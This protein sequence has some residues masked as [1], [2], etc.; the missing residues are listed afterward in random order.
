MPESVEQ[1]SSEG[2]TPLQVAVLAQR[3]DV[4]SYLISI[5]ANQRSRDKMGRTMVHSMVASKCG[6]A[7]THADKLQAMI[8]LFD[9]EAV[10]EMLVERCTLHPGALTPLGYWMATNGGRYKK[11][12]IIAI[13]SKYSTGQDLE[14]INGEG[15]LPLHVVCPF[16]SH[17]T[18]LL[19]PSIS[20]SEPSTNCLQAVRQNLSTIT[21]Y[22]LTLNTSLLYR[23]NATGPTPL[24]MSRETYIASQVSGPPSF[25]S[26]SWT[27]YRPGQ[28]EYKSII[29]KSPSE[30]V[31]KENGP[32]ETQKGT[33]EV[34][35][36]I[37]KGMAKD[38]NKR[39]RRLVSLFEANE[40]AKRVAGLK[41]RFG[42]VVNGGLV[43]CEV[44][45]D[46]VS[47]LLGTTLY[48]REKKTC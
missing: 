5:R 4:V 12:D 9:K 25:S 31:K 3:P 15:D 24:E 20:S 38:G 26:D 21:S 48:V 37:D 18:S 45:P 33:W 41:R 10:K 19:L 29:K 8:R 35:N 6:F 32:E 34:C 27:Q 39:K 36:A 11:P 22:L 30:F 1:K 40:V 43:D 14:M 44:K 16:P 7:K 2:W 13:L 42:V 47:E 28:T 23:E 17:S 46:V